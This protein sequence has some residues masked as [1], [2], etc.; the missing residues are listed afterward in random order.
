LD[1]LRFLGG[2]LSRFASHKG[3]WLR[4]PVRVRWSGAPAR[5]ATRH[6]DGLFTGTK[7]D[8]PTFAKSLCRTL[9]PSTERGTSANRPGS[10]AVRRA[11][12]PTMTE[13]AALSDD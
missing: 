5:S 8:P 11:I 10:S 2:H 6:G 12:G 13:V 4:V 3:W 7:L 9:C 1:K